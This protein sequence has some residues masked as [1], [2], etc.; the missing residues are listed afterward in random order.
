[1]TKKSTRIPEEFLFAAPLYW[2]ITI[3]VPSSAIPIR[4]ARIRLATGLRQLHGPSNAARFT[5]GTR[6]YLLSPI[7]LAVLR[8]K[9][10]ERHPH[11]SFSFFFSLEEGAYTMPHDQ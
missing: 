5:G 4:A 6:R 7:L 1:M 9:V 11:V 8:Q 2:P 10:L 3:A